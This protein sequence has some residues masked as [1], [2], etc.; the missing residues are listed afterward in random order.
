MQKV[1]FDVLT[2]WIAALSA[3]SSR[4]E[5]L[6]AP[7]TERRKYE[8]WEQEENLAHGLAEPAQFLPSASLP[9]SVG[10]SERFESSVN[11]R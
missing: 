10:K 8:M 1:S 2:Y 9:V 3:E 7:S 4:L 5:L 6:E 11:W